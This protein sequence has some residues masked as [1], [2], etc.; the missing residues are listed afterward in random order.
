[1][2]LN[3]LARPYAKAAFELARDSRALPHWSGALQALTGLVADPMIA[4]LLTDPRLSRSA[5]AQVLIDALGQGLDAQGRNL[6]RL[7]AQNNRLAVLPAIA[8]EFEALRAEAE[9]RVEVEIT[10]AA[11]VAD[12][13][14]VALVGAV[15]KRL[16]R[17]VQVSWKTDASLV[18]GAVIRAGDLVIDGS[19]AGELAQLRQSLIAN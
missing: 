7:L 9:R 19:V 13:Q 2:E 4:D 3:T 11:A 14:R 16:S 12:Q 10:T 18:A 5:V 15:S 6:V 8:E 1:M 17:E